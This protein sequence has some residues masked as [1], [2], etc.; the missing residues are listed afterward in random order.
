MESGEEE[1]PTA[2]NIKYDR[3]KMLL[4]KLF[5]FFVF[6]LPGKHPFLW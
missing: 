6:F 1:L 2:L 3:H 5:F 4:Q